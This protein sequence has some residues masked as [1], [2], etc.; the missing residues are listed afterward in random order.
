MKNYIYIDD[1]CNA[2]SITV[3]VM[4]RLK[5]FLQRYGL[6]KLFTSR[7]EPTIEYGHFIY[8]NSHKYLSNIL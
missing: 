8:D 1:I 2:P 5:Y 7:I 4:K 3:N 6:E